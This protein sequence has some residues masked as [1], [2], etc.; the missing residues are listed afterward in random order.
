M[1]FNVDISDVVVERMQKHFQKNF[2]LQEY[3]PLDATK[4]PMRDNSMSICLDKG[5]YDALACGPESKPILKNLVNE[6]LRVSSVATV[7]ISSGTESKR[8][9]FF[10][11][12]TAETFPN[13]KIDQFKLEL[14]TSAQL[15]NILRTELKDKPLSHAMKDKAVLKRAMQELLN[16]EKRKMENIQAIKDPRKKLLAL[17]MKAKMKRQ[18]E[19]FDQTYAEKE[20]QESKEKEQ[21]SAEEKKVESQKREEEEERK[22]YDPKRQ[23][24]VM[25]YVLWKP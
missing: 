23:D 6:M 17:M 20:N 25:M 4:M 1:L 3:L 7:I 24:F 10:K 16:I 21:E 5:T 15:I 13:L 12:Y 22:G 11:E 18:Q 2:P 14:S 9:P 19:Q 8:V